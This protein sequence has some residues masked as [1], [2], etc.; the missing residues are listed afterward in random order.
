MCFIVNI[1]LNLYHCEKVCTLVRGVNNPTSH[2]N[3]Q[4]ASIASISSQ[5]KV[6]GEEG[7]CGCLTLTP[8]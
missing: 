7:V 5:V 1:K 3:D 8:E 4:F 6:E 2:S